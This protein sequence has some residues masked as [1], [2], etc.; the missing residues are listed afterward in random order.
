MRPR[1]FALLAASIVLASGCGGNRPPVAPAVDLAAG[2]RAAPPEA[3]ADGE[4]LV[5]GKTGDGPRT[6]YR[7]AG[8][9]RVLGEE[10]AVVIMT[11][12][13]ELVWRERE[14][15]VKLGGCEEGTPGE[16][17]EPGK[18]THAWLAPRD[19]QPRQV[20][21]DPSNEGDGVEQL[22]HVVELLGSVG[23]YLFVH[24]NV[25]LFAC[26]PHGN[27][28][29]SFHL[30][31]AE[32]GKPLDLLLDLPNKLTLARRAEPMLDEGDMDPEEARKE[33][34]LPELVQI[35]PVYGER[36]GLRVDAQFMRAD[37][38]ACSD[39]L[40]STYTRSVILP[41]EWMPERFAAWSTPPVA[42]V[43]FLQSRP[44]FSLGGWSR[45]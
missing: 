2:P 45:R 36:G 1:S 34:D 7:V 9:G 15:D 23:P 14:E 29:A 4:V 17:L 41:S 40:W 25:D 18:V 21:V 37:C 5:W 28:M 10:P 35:Q 42:V 27:S 30:W 44:G 6:T 16:L 38:Y 43:R 3:E 11:S 22:T 33:E 24:E 19:D 32:A 13:G 12:R 26:G 20:V 39:G 31:D 8:D